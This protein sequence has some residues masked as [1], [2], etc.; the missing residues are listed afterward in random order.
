ML[1]ALVLAISRLVLPNRD[2][3]IDLRDRLQSTL[4]GGFSIS[5]ELGGGGRK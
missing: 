2:S 4:G 1:L 3:V 5:R